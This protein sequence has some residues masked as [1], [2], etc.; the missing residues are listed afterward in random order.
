MEHISPIRTQRVKV[1]PYNLEQLG[2]HFRNHLDI[3]LN[4]IIK[5]TI[6]AVEKLFVRNYGKS[7]VE[8]ELILACAFRVLHSK[9][10]FF[11]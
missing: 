9:R 1:P 7:F 6:K 4:K 8:M 5:G 2:C 11:G 3:F 10:C